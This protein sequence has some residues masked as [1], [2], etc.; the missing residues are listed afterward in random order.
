MRLDKLRTLRAR[1]GKGLRELARAAGI[2]YTTLV[3]LENGHHK[4]HLATL[5]KLAAVLDVDVTELLEYLDM[6]GPE[7][8]RKSQAARRQKPRRNRGHVL[9]T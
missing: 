7:R 4:A 8:G 3:A 5:G 2:H 6:S 9:D 1:Q